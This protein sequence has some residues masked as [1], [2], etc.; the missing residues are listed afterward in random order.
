V[1]CRRLETFDPSVHWTSVTAPI[2]ASVTEASAQ[3][4]TAI[5][6]ARRALATELITLGD[7]ALRRAIEHVNARTQFGAQI[8]SF[9]SP[10]HALA[11]AFAELEGA[12]ALLDESWR[13]GGAM[14]AQAA[15]AAAGRAH[16]AVADVALQVCGA[17]G[18]TAEHELHRYVRRGIQ[19]DSLCGSYAL[20]EA[21]LADQLFDPAAAQ[22][23]ALVSCG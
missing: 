3:W 9:Q 7:E 13:F 4:T 16:R 17:I 11:Q 6:A 18:L 1:D 23:P 2:P 15:K 5:G 20:L 10:R 22:L 19:L 21:D 8:G 14:S 12:R